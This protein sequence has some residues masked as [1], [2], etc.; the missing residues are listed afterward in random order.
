M[1]FWQTLK[2]KFE[3]DKYKDEYQDRIKDAIDKKISGKKIKKVKGKSKR[4]V[5]DLMKAL[6]ESLKDAK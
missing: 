6:E 3:P 1:T 4:S 5:S 2:G